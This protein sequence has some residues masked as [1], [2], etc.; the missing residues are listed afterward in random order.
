MQSEEASLLCRFNFAYITEVKEI[1]CDEKSTFVSYICCSETVMKCR[2]EHSTFS[3]VTL[4]V[5][6]FVNTPEPSVSSTA[7][8]CFAAS[9]EVLV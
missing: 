6:T 4:N 1:L 8:L 2:E 7:T 5:Y 3:L 9:W